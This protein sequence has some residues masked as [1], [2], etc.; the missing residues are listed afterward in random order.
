ME[1]KS[2]GEEKV[3]LLGYATIADRCRAMD[4]SHLPFQEPRCRIL[5][6]ALCS[7]TQTFVQQE[8][9]QQEEKGRCLLASSFVF[10]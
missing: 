5:H 4:V 8:T 2:A 7:G 1:N 3:S 9:R 6:P 10:T